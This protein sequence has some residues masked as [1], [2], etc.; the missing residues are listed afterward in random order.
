MNFNQKKRRTKKKKFRKAPIKSF[1]WT[2]TPFLHSKTLPILKKTLIMRMLL[3]LLFF[4]HKASSIAKKSKH[5]K[6]DKKSRKENSIPDLVSSEEENTLS[7]V[8]FSEQLNSIAFPY[9]P[10][11]FKTLWVLARRTNA[12]TILEQLKPLPLEMGLF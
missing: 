3:I 5:N 8:D 1:L 10:F 7:D 12:S 6:K 11:V 2:Q 4:Q 9:F